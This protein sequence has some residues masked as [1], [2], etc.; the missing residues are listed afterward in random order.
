MD[1][2]IPEYEPF[3]VFKFNDAPLISDNYFKFR[4]VSSKTLSEILRISVKDWKL[5]CGSP[6]F[7]DFW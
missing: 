5:S 3:V 2:S 7:V 6:I 1:T 4:H